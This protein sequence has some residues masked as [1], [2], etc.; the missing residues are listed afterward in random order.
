MNLNWIDHEPQDAELEF[1]L[2]W[3]EEKFTEM[4]FKRNFI[5]SAQQQN[6]QE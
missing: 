2:E 3:Q 5:S 1:K 6:G 4:Q